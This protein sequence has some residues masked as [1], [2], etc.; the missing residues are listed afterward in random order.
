MV[1]RADLVIVLTDVNSHGGVQLARR[2][3]QRLGRAALIVR[4]CGAAQ[5][6]NLLDALAARGQRDL[7][8]ALA[9]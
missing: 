4:R 9:S 5:F 1:E 7:A 6:Q 2:I 8:A 3:C